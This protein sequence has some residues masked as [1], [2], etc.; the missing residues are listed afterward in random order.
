MP[1]R[2]HDYTQLTR[3]ISH[4]TVGRCHSRFAKLDHA[5]VP[6]AASPLEPESQVGRPST[7]IGR[8]PLNARDTP[9]SPE[10]L[11]TAQSAFQHIPFYNPGAT[12]REICGPEL[13]A[14]RPPQREESSTPNRLT[15]AR[16][17]LPA[18]K[19]GGAAPHIVPLTRLSGGVVIAH[20]AFTLAP[21]KRRSP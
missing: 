17:P 10:T 20:S 2:M 4:T 18:T 7:P 16:M 19:S 6:H 14:R 12:P 15:P 1:R 9:I 5:D 13:R 8:K 11:S 3:S 21:P